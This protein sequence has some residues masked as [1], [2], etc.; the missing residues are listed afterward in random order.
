MARLDDL[1]P[2][3]LHAASLR[4]HHDRRPSHAHAPRPATTLRKPD[5]TWS[6]EDTTRIVRQVQKNLLGLTNYGVFDSLHFG[7]EG[8][9]LILQ[10]YASRPTLKSD[11]ENAVKNIQGVESV[12]N[13]IKVLP[14]SLLDDRI[15][16]EVYRRIYTQPALRKYT[17][18]PVGFGRFPSVAR[19]A[20]GITQDPPLGYHAIHII[21]DN[22]HV[23]LKG[24]VNSD[25]D[26]AIAGIQANTAPGAF[27]V[28]N[29]LEVAGTRRESKPLG[30]TFRGRICRRPTVRADCRRRCSRLALLLRESPPP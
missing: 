13:Q 17:G 28:Q 8:H 12:D 15:R 6:Q 25:S 16:A 24:V 7:I 11:A 9:T 18:S 23:I 5:P 4:P 10:G 2:R 3:S 22:G 30:P 29:D 20:G 14:N 26:A 19:A 27:S 21:V 1:T